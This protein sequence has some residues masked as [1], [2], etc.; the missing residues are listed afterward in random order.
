MTRE[1]VQT[2]NAPK[3]IGPYR[4]GHQSQRFHLYGGTDTHRPENRQ[5][6]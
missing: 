5:L 2:D 6:G 3:A 4:A 1:S